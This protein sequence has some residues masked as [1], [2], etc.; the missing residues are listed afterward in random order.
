MHVIGLLDFFM[1][2]NGARCVWARMS[3][4]FQSFELH[5]S[6]WPRILHPCDFAQSDI[7]TPAIVRA[8][9]EGAGL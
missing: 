5:A 6:I 4:H 3:Q 9:A 1:D 8:T 7:C 2:C